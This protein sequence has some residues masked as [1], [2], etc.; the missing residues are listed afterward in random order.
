[1]T[2]QRYLTD[3]ER[4]YRPDYM[5]ALYCH[6]LDFTIKGVQFRRW[7]RSEAERDTYKERDL[8]TGVISRLIDQSTEAL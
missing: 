3:A 2:W 5:R 6:P 4:K 1:M 7:F 8:H